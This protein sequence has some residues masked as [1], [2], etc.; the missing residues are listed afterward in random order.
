MTLLKISIISLEIFN[1]MEETSI[2]IERTMCDGLENIVNVDSNDTKYLWIKLSFDSDTTKA[3]LKHTNYQIKLINRVEILHSSLFNASRKI[4]GLFD[5]YGSWKSMI[6]QVSNEFSQA[7]QEQTAENVVN[8]LKKMKPFFKEKNWK[9]SFSDEILKV[10]TDITN[11]MENENFTDYYQRLL[12]IKGIGLPTM[13][14]ILHSLW[15]DKFPYYSDE[16]CGYMQSL[17]YLKNIQETNKT[18]LYEVYRVT[19][20][21]IV[22][23]VFYQSQDIADYNS[24]SFFIRKF[25]GYKF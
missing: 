12:D 7:I 23:L 9:E 24:I 15:S 16:F 2:R 11:D 14:I 5:K 13:S 19:I 6:N 22:K 1:D 25:K 3:M 20:N 18:S 21:R 10:L 17:G 8:I 4:E